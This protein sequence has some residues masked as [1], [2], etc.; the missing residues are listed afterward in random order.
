M[1][2]SQGIIKTFQFAVFSCSFKVASKSWVRLVK[3]GSILPRYFKDE[4]VLAKWTWT[5]TNTSCVLIKHCFADPMV[6]YPGAGGEMYMYCG[7]R[8]SILK[9]ILHISLI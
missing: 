9:H 6:Q 8:I 4:Y 2:H 3:L 5:S 1:R 7:H